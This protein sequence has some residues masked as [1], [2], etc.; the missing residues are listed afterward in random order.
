MYE[1][2]TKCPVCENTDYTNYSIVKD[3]MITKEDFHLSK[4]SN[5]E[6]I[7]TNPRP[8]KEH[9]GKYYQSDVYVSHSDTKKGIINKLYHSVRKKSLKNKVSIVKE[10]SPE[11]K[12]ILDYG[13]GTGYFPE[14]LKQY[15]YEVYAFEPDENARKQTKDKIKDNVYDNIDEL[16]DKKFDVITLWHVLEHIHDLNETIIKLTQK[17]KPKGTIIVAVPNHNAPERDYYKNEW[18][19][20]D[21]PRH[22]YHFTKN[23]IK[24]LFKKHKYS[25]K[26]VLP[27][28][29]DSYYVS[30][31][32]EEYITGKKSLFKAYKRGKASNKKAKANNEYSSL[33]YILKKK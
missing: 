6:F 17:L 24:E 27:M 33:I 26:D 2:V 22:L 18:A 32:S 8:D 9:I 16:P 23:S 15:Q 30:L 5:C 1:K 4:C 20:Y 12:T 7:F 11:A 28:K 31:L 3:H 21:V 14:I 19:A 25:L 10:Y 29:Y 13:S